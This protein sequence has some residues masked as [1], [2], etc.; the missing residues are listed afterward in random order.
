MEQTCVE[1]DLST[2][3][4]KKSISV[5]VDSTVAAAKHHEQQRRG[6]AARHAV[7]PYVRLQNS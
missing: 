7:A 4:H 5:R 2:P 3:V 1:G 6:Y